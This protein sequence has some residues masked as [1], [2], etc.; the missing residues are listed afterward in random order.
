VKP[1]KLHFRIA[2]SFV[3]LLL[4]ALVA[5]L[6]LVNLTLSTS[7]QNDIEQ[8]LVAGERVFGLLIED[9]RRQLLQSA[10]I[11]SS[12][13]AFR[14]AVTTADRG[15]VLSALG[16]HGARINAD[17]AMLVGMDGKVFA[18]TQK[19]D[20]S[21][22]PFAF[23]NMILAAEQQR[24]AAAMVLMNHKLY[25]LVVVPVLAPLPVGWL[26]IGFR[27]DDRLAHDLR[28]LTLLE[29]SFAAKESP[30][31]K[32]QIVASTLSSA[33]KEEMPAV[34]SAIDYDRG[35]KIAL[36]VGS[37]EYIAHVVSMGP[38]SSQSVTAIL[39]RSVRRALEP[40]HHL[41]KIMLLLGGVSLFA[42]V[43][44]S[45]LLARGITKPIASLAT[46]AGR[47]AQGDYSEAAPIE[48]DD[49][50]GRLA[51]AF[52]HMREG[53][54]TREA[55]ISELAFRD[56]LTGLPNRA[57]F[58]DRLEQCIRAAKREGQ[59]F[60][61]LLLD[62]DR[63]KE[64]NEI[65]GHHVGDLLLQEVGK[66][67]EAALFRESDAVARLGGDEFAVLLSST[68]DVIG[69][70][71][72][73]RR[74]LDTLDRPI[75]LEHQMVA[76]SGSI[77][78]ACY[79]D[80]GEE[81]G[82]LMRHADL[83]MYVAKDNRSGF[84]IFDPTLDKHGHERLSLMSEL[85]HA[86]EDGQLVLYYQPKVSMATGVLGSVEALV[87]W[88]H[89]ERGMVSPGEFIPFAE[90]TGFIREITRWAIE[91]ALKQ[92]I[93]WANEGLPLRISVNVSARDLMKTDFPEMITTLLG[94]YDASPDWLALEI[95]ESAVMADP[96]RALSVL[97][98]LH[99][100]GLRLSVDDFGVGYSSLSYLKKL[101]VSELKI[102][103]SFVR[104]MDHD[105][106]DETIVRSTIDLGHN[107][108]LTVVAEGVETEVIWNMLRE[109]GCDVAQGY[110]LSRPLDAD[111]LAQ[112]IVR[113]AWNVAQ[114]K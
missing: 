8:S 103:M 93:K 109:M 10:S 39:Q 26:A 71:V 57:L 11:L 4:V 64:V 74:L 48:R 29:M 7:A 22:Q 88:R 24:Q 47:I 58:H 114:E 72:I 90:N 5:S 68:S 1:G 101:P 63:F 108:G 42:G 111:P 54:S 84:A 36:I 76:S 82:T 65:L 51:N 28:S 86:L 98:R 78:V 81:V 25:Q 30:A 16:N 3:F 61:V 31:D 23:P 97:E 112:W 75:E 69:V 2:I 106:N 9:N 70:Q 34:L 92:R 67:L 35:S 43:I 77:G 40:L 85:R 113:S 56:Q 49:E 50:V 41:Q 107:M 66:R 19:S 17:V 80:H 38:Q 27:I 53:I 62:L 83:A 104:N 52:N 96:Q 45:L 13:F 20:S 73:V 46:L 55:R 15:T 14:Q 18:D 21:G 79:P 6:A 105:K 91:A 33:S 100:I 94:R 37:E 32:W 102:D 59:G 89:P 110:Y 87:R 60:A 12:D 44:A 95:T 99:V